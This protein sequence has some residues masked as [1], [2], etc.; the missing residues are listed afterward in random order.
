[1]IPVEAIQTAKDTEYGL[2]GAVFSENGARPIRVA[3]A[4]EDGNMF[5]NN[6]GLVENG[7]R[8]ESYKQSGYGRELGE[9]A[10]EMRVFFVTSW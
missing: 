2:E 10:L 3:H 8:S 5:V 7:C 6:H 9:Y 1:M 4:L